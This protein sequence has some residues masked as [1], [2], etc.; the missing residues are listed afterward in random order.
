[1]RW[2]IPD[3]GFAVLP[4]AFTPEFDVVLDNADQI[5]HAAQVINSYRDLRVWQDA[6]ALAEQKAG[7]R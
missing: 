7:S 3:S 4:M 6:M 5:R 2:T 1:M